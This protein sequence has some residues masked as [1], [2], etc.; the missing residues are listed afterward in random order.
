M[1]SD[2]P[3][4]SKKNLILGAIRGYMADQLRPFIA[5][6][7]RVG[8]SGDVVFLWNAV[9]ADSRRELT[10]AG[11]KLVHMNYRGNGTLNSWSR[12][13]PT[14][15]PVISAT[16]SW[17]AARHFFKSLLPLQTVRF[18]EYRDF[19][20]KHAATYGNVLI[21]DV[22]DVIFQEDPFCGFDSGL[23][24]FEEDSQ[25][26]LADETVAN[27]PW[28]SHLFGPDAL[29]K[30]GRFPILCSGTTMGD[31]QGMLDYLA[32]FEALSFR[33]REIGAAGSDQ[34]IHNYLCRAETPPGMHVVPNGSG[35]VLTMS[36]TMQL[37]RDFSFD[38]NRQILNSKGAI[39]PLL[40]QYD[41]HP[42]VAAA[43]LAR[44]GC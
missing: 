1:P 6:L 12:F 13:W 39:A 27:A 31:S 14:V 16:H 15:A 10:Q 37:D 23:A 26:A 8:F 22:R 36:A 9:D 21:T 38:S 32:A 33:A 28:V 41:R 43:L 35:P 18:F 25:I 3:T 7:E 4:K 5:S 44:L 30:I 2:K 17:G 40:H 34:G 19:L 20:A 11:I 42:K 29:K 24:V